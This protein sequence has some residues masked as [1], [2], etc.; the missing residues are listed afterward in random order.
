MSRV[1]SSGGDAPRVAMPST[2]LSQTPGPS[3]SQLH[4]L[5]LGLPRLGA[6][7][8]SGA[9]EDASGTMKKAQQSKAK[10]K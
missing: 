3:T 8:M 2:A 4:T 10:K 7:P 9:A 1:T 5:L 6:L